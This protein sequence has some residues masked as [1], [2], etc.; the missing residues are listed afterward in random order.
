MCVQ[1]IRAKLLMQPFSWTESI[2]EMSVHECYH[3]GIFKSHKLWIFQAGGM[4]IK[5]IDH[6]EKHWEQN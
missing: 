4:S 6:G 5:N 3:N 1:S 2:Y